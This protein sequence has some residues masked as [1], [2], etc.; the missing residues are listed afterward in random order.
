MLVESHLELRPKSIR[1]I[2]S[3][4]AEPGSPNMKFSAIQERLVERLVR[5]E[6][7]RNARAEKEHHE[8][9][10]IQRRACDTFARGLLGMNFVIGQNA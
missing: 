5:A 7:G 10:C 9:V 3:S 4:S 8:G 1:K 6:N 2:L